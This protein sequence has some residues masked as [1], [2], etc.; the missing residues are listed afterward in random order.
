MKLKEGDWILEMHTDTPLDVAY[1]SEVLTIKKNKVTCKTLL[2]YAEKT[3]QG[4]IELTIRGHKI[5]Y[6]IPTDTSLTHGELRDTNHVAPRLSYG[7]SSYK[8]T[9]LTKEE[10]AKY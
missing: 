5:T 9:I 8:Y 6:T 1:V 3:D 10:K 2:G 4:V 7:R